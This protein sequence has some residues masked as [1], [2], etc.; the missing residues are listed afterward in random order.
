MGSSLI[1]KLQ[2]LTNDTDGVHGRPIEI[3]N[4]ASQQEHI[5]EHTNEV[6]TLL[7]AYSR[8]QQKMQELLTLSAEIEAEMK[9]GR[10][11]LSTLQTG[12]SRESSSLTI[13][14]PGD[15]QPV[16]TTPDHTQFTFYASC[17]GR[18]VIYYRGSP[19]KLCSNRNAQAMLRFLIAQPDHSASADTL[20]D[21][22]WPED[23]ADVA[24]RKMHVTVSILRNT[25]RGG[26]NL[27]YHFILYKH[28]VYR[29][30]PAVSLHSDIEEFLSL[31]H[32]GQKS[33]GEA[34][35]GHFEKACALYTRPFLIEDLYANWSFVY[36]EQFRQ[37]YLHMSDVL[38]SYYLALQT[39]D[40]AAQWTMR[41]IKEN[42]CDEVAHRRLMRIYTLQGRRNDALRQYR[43]CQR[44]LHEELNMQPLAETEALYQAI[45]KGDLEM[46]ANIHM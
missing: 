23:D 18:F 10:I 8:L 2:I 9:A 35:I 42:A 25:L 41:I 39:Y 32:M 28:G 13:P 21:M 29:L 31:Y 11:A 30:D 43:T 17:F 33:T 12:L 37:M 5:Q 22:F 14:A 45:L 1:S 20:M 16:A 27:P 3:C 40:A 26:C 7:S 4:E 38:S 6:T 19:L 46:V 36:R 34:A 15:I 44:I 24:S